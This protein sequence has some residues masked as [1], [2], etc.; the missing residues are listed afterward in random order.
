M[1]TTNIPGRRLPRP[2]AA[3]ARGGTL[4]AALPAALLSALFLAAACGGAPAVPADAEAP[5]PSAAVSVA[6]LDAL[7]AQ[8]AAALDSF[9]TV[10]AIRS[11]VG[12]L[13]LAGAS[14]DPLVRARAE[15]ARAELVRVG[16]RLSLEPGELWIKADGTQAE[17]SVR[18]LGKP[19]ALQ[20]AVYLYENYG[21]VKTPVADAPIAFQFVRGKGV[22]VESVATDFE[23]RANTT[24]SRLDEAA[25]GAAVRAMPVFEEKGYRY[26]FAE[27]IRDFVYLPPSK[28]AKVVAVEVAQGSSRAAPLAADLVSA[29]ARD[30]G[31]DPAVYDKA[32]EDARFAAAMAGDPAVLRALAAET[33]A[34]WFVFL[35]IEAGEPRQMVVSGK[36]YNIWTVDAKASLRLVRD[37]G[38][39]AWSKPVD[40]IRGQGGSAALSLE[41]AFQ[42]AREAAAAAMDSDRAAILAAVSAP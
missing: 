8:A 35:R 28:L 39:A 20:P 3:T 19:G 10:E 11:W 13:G 29:K 27:L 40:G 33:G 6:E 1:K 16:K 17:A 7:L 36:A 14:S 5:A 26:A 15:T 25:K 9:H 24:V 42:L 23:G 41:N 22:L 32:L 37:D 34:A 12:V 21:T 31:L 30:A 4:S 38:T 18:G 2:S